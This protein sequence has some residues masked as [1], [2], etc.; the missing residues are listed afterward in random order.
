M[1]EFSCEKIMKDCTWSKKARTEE[2]L[3]D[4]VALHL[5][6]VH[7]M[8]ALTPVMVGQIKNSF[9]DPWLDDAAGTVDTIM[10]E[11]NCN[12]EPRCTW[13]FIAQAEAILTGNRSVHEKELLGR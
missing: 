9:R 12:K 3:M 2:L 5:R 11:Y 6:D 7:Q 10:E 8:Q 4:M 13:E 1:K